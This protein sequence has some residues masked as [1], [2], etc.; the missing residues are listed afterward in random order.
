MA[1]LQIFDDI[2]E[3]T[4]SVFSDFCAGLKDEE[5]ALI[6]ICSH[7]GL[8]FYSNAIFQ[9][10]Q[11]AQKRSCFF[12]A[13]IYGIAA[14]SAADIALACDRVEMA[15][16]SAIMIHSAF[17]PDGDQDEGI[18]IANEAQLSVIKKRIPEYDMESLKDDQWFRADEALE[19]GLIDAI[20]DDAYS[21]QSKIAA[22]LLNTFIEGGLIM[23]NNSKIKAKS[24]AKAEEIKKEEVIEEEKAEEI[25]EEEKKEEVEEIKEDR[26]PS[27][28][29][30]FERIAERLEE[31]AKDLDDV[32]ER[33][34]KLEGGEVQAEC[35]NDEKENSR[36]KAVYDRIQA[37]CK[38]AQPK[39]IKPIQADPKEELDRYK[40]KYGNMNFDSYINR[41]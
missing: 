25:V 7:G 12:T 18:T 10:M 36:M 28:E 37:I 15:K 21:E 20:F 11:E 34:R 9:K 38:P 41:D 17:R 31:V 22:K 27:N 35:G 19:I 33:L 14:S 2:T 5:S 39:A 29:D 6:E 26:E 23:A 3:N 40:A 30:L 32:K 13:K 8:V 1:I 24:N 4:L 16:T